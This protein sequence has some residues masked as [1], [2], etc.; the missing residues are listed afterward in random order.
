LKI[1]D[2]DEG[3]PIENSYGGFTYYTLTMV[4][5]LNHLNQTSL[6]PPL[7]LVHLA[8]DSYA[9]EA[10]YINAFVFYIIYPPLWVVLFKGI[11]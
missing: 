5:P 1:W 11:F 10:N 9:D 2:S 4:Q 7:P 8:N 3:D 6:I